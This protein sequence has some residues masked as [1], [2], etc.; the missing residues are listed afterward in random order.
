M[1]IEV[2]RIS[3]DNP[4][5]PRSGEAQP[6]SRRP[7]ELLTRAGRRHCLDSPCRPAVCR[8]LQ[9]PARKLVGSFQSTHCQRPDCPV[10]RSHRS[11]ERQRSERSTSATIINAAQ[12]RAL[13]YCRNW[14]RRGAIGSDVWSCITWS[15]INCSF[16][17]CKCTSATL[18]RN[19]AYLS[20]KSASSVP[21]RESGR[22]S[23]A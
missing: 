2:A 10:A 8:P 22:K 7:L 20:L 3:A 9:R 19:R 6:T 13:V 16:R 17:F 4:A 21:V 1:P 18:R 5:T 15:C 11:F 23:V 14:P 12:Q